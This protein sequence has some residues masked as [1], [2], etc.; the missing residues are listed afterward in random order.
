MIYDCWNIRCDRQKFLS[1]WTIFCPF[2]PLTT[3][4]I[5]IFTLKKNTWRYYHFTHLHHTRQSYDVWFLRYGVHQTIFC[6][7]GPF[8][9]LLPLYEP[10]KSNFEKNEKKKIWRYYHFTNVHHKRQSYD[11]WFLRYGVQRTQ[12]FV[13]LGYFLPFY[14]TNNSKKSKFWK[15][16]KKKKKKKKKIF[17]KKKKKKTHLEILLFYTCVP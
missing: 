13:I 11:V 15:N 12:F 9:A 16:G 4:K 10:I 1:F 2:S 6:P 8:F 5:K 14:P 7:S 3:W 17:K